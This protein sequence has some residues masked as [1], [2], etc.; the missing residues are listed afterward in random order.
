MLLVRLVQQHGLLDQRIKGANPHPAKVLSI[1]L[2]IV[3]MAGAGTTLFCPNTFVNLRVT[4]VKIV[5]M[6]N[7]L[8]GFLLYM[9][10]LIPRFDVDKTH[11]ICENITNK[12]NYML[13]SNTAILYIIW[14][15]FMPYKSL[16]H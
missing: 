2:E 5:F 7:D 8:F 10:L 9:I 16:E 3:H 15:V 12:L 1:T 13:I 11:F 4:N 6:K 14:T